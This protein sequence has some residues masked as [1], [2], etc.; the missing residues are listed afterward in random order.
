M[1][2]GGEVYDP[3][4]YI[5][6]YVSER[7]LRR[8]RQLLCAYIHICVCIYTDKK[9]YDDIYSKKHVYIYIYTY[10]DVGE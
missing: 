6:I 1:M 4:I 5:I 3:Y 10:S 2:W 7:S 9:V 8:R